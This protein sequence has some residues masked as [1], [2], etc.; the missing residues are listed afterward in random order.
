MLE[1]H[2][3]ATTRLLVQGRYELLRMSKQGDPAIPKTKGNADAIA[4]GVRAYPFMFSRDG[5]AIHGEF[6][7]TKSIGVAPLSGD[8][9]GVDPLSDA[10]AVWSRSLLL[11]L[12]FAF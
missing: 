4:V 3:V 1:A 2:Y 10:T 9:S 12:D 8:G 6:S 11:A 5:L 7:M